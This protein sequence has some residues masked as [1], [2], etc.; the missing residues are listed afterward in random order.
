M[1]AKDRRHFGGQNY[2]VNLDVAFEFNVGVVESHQV[3]FNWRQVWGK[4]SICVDGEEVL[5]ENHFFG[6]KKTKVYKTT[7]GVS[8][9]H[10]VVIETTIIAGGFRKQRFRVFVDEVLLAEH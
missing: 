7:V 4:A 5:R 3:S 9:F 8:E 2:G 1:I 6:V 10:A